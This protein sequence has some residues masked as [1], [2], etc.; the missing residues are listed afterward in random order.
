MPLFVNDIWTLRRERWTGFSRWLEAFEDRATVVGTQAL[1][2]GALAALTLVLRS[3][4]TLDF[5]YFQF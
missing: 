1:T 2:V 3:N 4:V 5:I